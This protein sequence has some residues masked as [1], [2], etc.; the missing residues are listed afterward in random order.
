M[1]LRGE[2]WWVPPDPTKDSEITK[3]RPCLVLSTD[4]LN[5][6]RR[7][8]AVIPFSTS[9]RPSPPLLVPVTCAG[10]DAVAAI[11]QIRAVSKERLRKRI[12]LLAPECLADVESALRELLELE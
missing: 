10:R 2:V 6:R 5:E 8:V 1:P 11:D 7:T 3:T 4:I 12:G 9:L